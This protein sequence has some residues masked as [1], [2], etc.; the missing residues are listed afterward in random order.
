MKEYLNYSLLSHNTFGVEAMCDR[1]LEFSSTADAVEVA[2]QLRHSDS[3]LLIIGSG[4]NLLLTGDFKGIVVHSA[5]AGIE[6]LGHCQ[7]K[8]G[9]GVLWDDVVDYCVNHNL[10]GAENLSII[11]GEVGASAVQ[12]IG[13]YGAEASD[14]IVEVEAVEISTGKV[15]LIPKSECHYAYRQSRFS[16]SGATSI[17]L[18]TSHIS[19]L[20][21]SAQGLIMAIY[22]PSWLRRAYPTLRQPTCARW[23]STF[24]M[25]SCPILRCKATP[26]VSS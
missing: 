21:P 3:D 17:W 1:F 5:I 12:N 16:R 9:S 7:I 14:L 13:A 8:C 15:C 2:S 20:I 18:R 19:F 22:A 10:Y 25:P 26:A 24:A 23:L 4:S 6:D 11:P